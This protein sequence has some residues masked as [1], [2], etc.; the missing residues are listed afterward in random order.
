MPRFIYMCFLFLL[1]FPSVSLAIKPI[2][3]A[4]YFSGNVSQFAEYAGVAFISIKGSTP[5]QSEISDVE[6]RAKVA[7][8]RQFE[9]VVSSQTGD[10]MSESNGQS[11]QSVYSKG[12]FKTKLQLR[13]NPP[14]LWFDEDRHQL[15]A[16]V[17]IPKDKSSE[18]VKDAPL[19]YDKVMLREVHA[20]VYRLRNNIVWLK[21]DEGRKVRFK[22]NE[23]LSVRE[24]VVV[25]Y[26]GASP[27]EV[28]WEGV[29]LEGQIVSGN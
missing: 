25:M 14:A 7:L 18:W 27:R 4:E 24:R 23:D 19:K 16:R 13:T 20:L 29:K 5:T 28:Y 10:S 12:Q 1:C 15:W 2:W 22:T 9:S 6:K 11:S 8:A 21:T 17:S 26:K 3:V